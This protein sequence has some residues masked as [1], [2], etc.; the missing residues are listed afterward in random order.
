[1]TASN[2][3]TFSKSAKG[4]LLGKCHGIEHR[5]L[6]DERDDDGIRGSIEGCGIRR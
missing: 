5:N 2:W 3:L 4:R 6:V 1:M